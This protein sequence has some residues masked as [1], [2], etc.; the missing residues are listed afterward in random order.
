M[1]K[2]TGLIS[3]LSLSILGVDG[4]QEKH[5]ITMVNLVEMFY[6][7]FSVR[8]SFFHTMHFCMMIWLAEKKEQTCIKGFYRKNS[9]GGWKVPVASHSIDIGEARYACPEVQRHIIPISFIRSSMIRIWPTTQK[10]S[11]GSFYEFSENWTRL[12]NEVKGGGPGPNGIRDWE[13]GKA[14]RTRQW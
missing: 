1:N 4:V 13:L 3:F 12:G 14:K 11:L 9:W 8:L 5:R 6:K 2:G 7:P 10:H